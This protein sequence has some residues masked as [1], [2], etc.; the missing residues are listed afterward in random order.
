MNDPPITCSDHTA[1]KLTCIPCP[2]CWATS[3]HSDLLN[4]WWLSQEDD[5]PLWEELWGKDDGK[6]HSRDSELEVSQPLP[7]YQSETKAPSFPGWQIQITLP[8]PTADSSKWWAWKA[9]RPAN[10]MAPRCSFFL[11]R[12]WQN[13]IFIRF[14]CSCS[15]YIFQWNGKKSWNNCF[16]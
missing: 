14:E 3:I 5:C 9:G 6:D 8:P 7:A 12:E 13:G 16:R 1:G 15:R 4:G 11:Q 10:K 2:L